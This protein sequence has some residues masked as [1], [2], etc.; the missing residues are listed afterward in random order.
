V[1]GSFDNRYGVFSDFARDYVAVRR[2]LQSLPGDPNAPDWRTIL[3]DRGVD[4]VV[5]Y[6]PETGSVPYILA[7]R[8]LALDPAVSRVKDWTLLHLDGAAAVYGRATRPAYAGLKLDTERLAYAPPE[9]E[10]A[11]KDGIDE[12]PTSRPF[13]EAFTT[14]LRPTTSDAASAWMHLVLFEAQQ[15][16]YPHRLKQAWEATLATETFGGLAAS[17]LFSGP[18]LAALSTDVNLDGLLKKKPNE[19]PTILERMAF[20]AFQGFA[21]GVDE[22]PVEQLWLAIRACRRALAQNP[23]N[24]DAHGTLA[25]SY[26]YLLLRTRER[27]WV[28]AIQPRQLP[29]LQGIRRAQMAFALSSLLELSPDSLRGHQVMAELLASLGTRRERA[30]QLAGYLDMELEHR[31]AELRIIRRQ[32]RS[33][34]Q[35]EEEFRG[36]LDA[37]EKRNKDLAT[38]V[39]RQ[40][41]RF[42]LTRQRLT[43]PTDQAGKAFELNLAGEALKILQENADTLDEVG[44]SLMA[45]IAISSGRLRDVK[46][47]EL[48]PKDPMASDW[49]QVRLW[50]AVGKYDQAD[51]VLLRLAERCKQSPFLAS[52]LQR[53][54][55]HVVSRTGG[56]PSLNERQGIALLVG[57]AVLDAT[58]PASECIAIPVANEKNEVVRWALSSLWIDLPSEIRVPLVR[59][60]AASCFGTRVE[61]SH[62]HLVRGLLALEAGDTARAERAFAEVRKLF[63]PLGSLRSYMPTSLEPVSE[64]FAQKIAE[65]KRKESG[66]GGQ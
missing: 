49:F 1:K 40:R 21:Q 55:I 63:A 57:K 2:G 24:P 43:K 32:G 61:E 56:R 33:A 38:R 60:F 4:H 54:D 7:V 12:M 35:T 47:D 50:A 53:A 6:A 58:L 41:Q 13:W 44:K 31:Q 15:D 52:F 46:L 48:L 22:G 65:A 23:N 64:Q 27:M 5:L 59:H 16:T 29:L 25:N 30:E 14:P 11:P 51:E 26:R 36:E 20:H 28:N 45:E 42:Q 66:R 19:Q 8:N 17:G 9:Q 18:A 37:L 3:R 34:Y 62:V 10:R 39:E